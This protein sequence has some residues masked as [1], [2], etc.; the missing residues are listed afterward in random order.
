MTNKTLNPDYTCNGCLYLDTL[1]TELPCRTC[2]RNNLSGY[3]EDRYVDEGE[4]YNLYGEG[5]WKC[6]D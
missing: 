2:A 6:Q 4:V 5:E 1:P 3:Y